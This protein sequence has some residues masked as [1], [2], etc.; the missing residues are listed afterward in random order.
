MSLFVVFEKKAGLIR[1]ADSAVGE[2][3]LFDESPRDLYSPSSSRRSFIKEAKGTWIPPSYEELPVNSPE[4][5]QPVYL[6][7]RGKQTHILSCPMI[8]PLSASPPLAILQWQY[9]PNQIC[10]RVCTP[11]DDSDFL[12]VISFGEYGVEVQEVR[13]S[14]FMKGKGKARREEPARTIVDVGVD[15]GFMCRGGQWDKAHRFLQRAESFMSY[16][17]V[18]TVQPNSRNPD[19]G[20]YGWCRKDAHDWRVFWLGGMDKTEIDAAMDL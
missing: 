11:R 6:L 3:E 7:T 13:L 5:T 14:L 10:H 16:S 2:V 19:A 20:F 15:A 4:A 17:T 12:Q 1:I 9:P 8:T 18:S